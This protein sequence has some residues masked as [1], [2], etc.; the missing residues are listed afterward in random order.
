MDRGNVDLALNALKSLDLA[1][2]L[3]EP[4]LTALSGQPAQYQVGG[5]FPVPQITGFTN[6]GQQGVQFIPF[7]VQLQ[8]IPTVTDDDRIRM[9]LRTEVSSTNVNGGATIGGAQVPGLN[10]SNF[11]TTVELRHGQTLAIAGLI[12][13]DTTSSSDRVP[14][15]GSVP[16][17]G[18]LFSSD[19]ASYGESELVVLVTPYLASPIDGDNPLP[20]PGSD[21]FEPSDLDFFLMG[22][23]DG[24]H[25]EDY[26]TPVRAEAGEIGAFHRMHQKYILGQPGYSPGLFAPRTVEVSR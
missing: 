12:T 6:A 10:T 13:T 18:R 14:G 15:L 24:R 22:R 23:I 25:G 8:F 1:R 16:V 21:H 5:S 19:T 7:G 17:L 2:T 4:T 11:L 26:R 20:V 3:S 9:Q